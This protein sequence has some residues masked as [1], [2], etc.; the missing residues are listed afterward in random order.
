MYLFIRLLR[1]GCSCSNTLVALLVAAEDGQGAVGEGN[2]KACTRDKQRI[3]ARARH[4]V[5]GVIIM[6]VLCCQSL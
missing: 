4:P 2:R 6:L 3:S 1:Y 5:D